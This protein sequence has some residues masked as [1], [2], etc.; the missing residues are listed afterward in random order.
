MTRLLAAIVTIAAFAYVAATGQLIDLA[1]GIAA[2]A[3]ASVG[4]YMMPPATNDL[5]QLCDHLLLSL[6]LAGLA[7]ASGAVSVYSDGVFTLAA[8][9]ALVLTLL[10][11]ASVLEQKLNEKSGG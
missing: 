4:F 9:M 8:W 3:V 2:G 6:P 10:V 7:I 11:P 5:K 1:G